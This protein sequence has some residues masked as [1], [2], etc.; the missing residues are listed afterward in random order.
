MKRISRA[1]HK[2]LP[3]VITLI[4]IF[5]SGFMLVNFQTLQAEEGAFPG[6]QAPSLTLTELE[7]G[8]EVSL[9]Q[10]DDEMV[11]LNFWTTWCP[12][13]GEDMPDLQQIEDEYGDKAAVLTV[14]IGES[15]EAVR[16]YMEEENYDFT[17][18]M[19]G[20]EEAAEQFMVRGVPTT[21]I[22]DD[23]NNTILERHVG[24]MSYEQKLE[25]LELN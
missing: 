22:L 1:N 4:L 7:S 21:F 5:T 19:D 20:D 16:S 3:L 12:V 17:V 25:L 6:E 18:L 10:F 15:A 24:P 11:L 23:E 14:N 8:E 9:D 2:A 13:C